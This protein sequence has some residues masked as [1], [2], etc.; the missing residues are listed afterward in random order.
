MP[1]LLGRLASGLAGLAQAKALQS[2]CGVLVRYFCG[3]A[4]ATMQ[5]EAAKT[6]EWPTAFRAVLPFL[7]LAGAALIARDCKP[8][9]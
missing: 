2:D 8:N 9:P 5:E 4:L 6:A 7:G 1:A 3:F